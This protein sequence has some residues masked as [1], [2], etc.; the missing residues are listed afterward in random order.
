[1]TCDLMTSHHIALYSIGCDV[2]F[3]DKINLCFQNS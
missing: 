1:M 3:I 2:S